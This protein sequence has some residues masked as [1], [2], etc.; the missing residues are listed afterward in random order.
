MI[1]KVAPPGRGCS[2]A[3]KYGFPLQ[4]PQ[5][6]KTRVHSRKGARM[7]HYSRMVAPTI[8]P[9]ME[10]TSTIITTNLTCKR[11]PPITNITMPF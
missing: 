2:I 8:S 6:G 10:N 11:A 7:H 9:K 5:G 4:F 3:L 1:M